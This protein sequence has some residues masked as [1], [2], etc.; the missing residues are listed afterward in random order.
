MGMQEKHVDSDMQDSLAQGS[1]S[2][3][4]SFSVLDWSGVAVVCKTIV[5]LA[6]LPPY[7]APRFSQMFADFGGTLPA[8]TRWITSYPWL[9]PLAALVLAMLV[10]AGLAAPP[11]SLGS[12]RRLLVVAF[13]VAGGALALFVWGL[14]MP[15]FAL[16]GSL[17]AE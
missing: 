13:L 9:G 2:S 14:Y 6:S 7:L 8:L 12:R 1:V 17:K 5:A 4:R 3:V 16:A 11:L 15:I 10:A